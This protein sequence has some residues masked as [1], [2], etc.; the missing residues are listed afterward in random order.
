MPVEFVYKRYLQPRADRSQFALESDFFEH[1]IIVVV[2]HAFKI[3]PPKVSRVLMTKQVAVPL[4]RWRMLRQSYCQYP[5][6]V[7]HLTECKVKHFD[8]HPPGIL[9]K[10]LNDK[11]HKIGGTWI[12][13]DP[14]ETPD[15]VIYYIHG[16]SFTICEM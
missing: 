9:T 8:N 13:H 15:L 12:K 7:Q 11:Q 1:F 4:L 14:D 6:H 2:R 10:L 16:R 3:L 5:S